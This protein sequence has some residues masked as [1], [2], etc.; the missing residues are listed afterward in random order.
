MEREDEEQITVEIG[1]EGSQGSPR[2]VAPR[3]K[4]KKK[5]NL[6][7]P[8]LQLGRNLI[9]SDSSACDVQ[10]PFGAEEGSIDAKSSFWVQVSKRES[11]TRNTTAVVEH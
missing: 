9:I 8:G 3:K 11:A 4:K 6:K 5:S 7:Q 2:A 10:I 1:C